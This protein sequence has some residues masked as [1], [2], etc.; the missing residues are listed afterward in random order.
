M[1]AGQVTSTHK[2]TSSTSREGD[3]RSIEETLQLFEP[4]TVPGQHDTAAF[5]LPW[6]SPFP[7]GLKA[8]K[9]LSLSNSIEVIKSF[10][11][12]GDLARLIK[13]HAGAIL[14]RGL[15]IETP[16]DYSKVAHAF[17]FRPHVEVGRPPLRTVLAP[18]VKT[19]NEGEYGWSTI[20]PAW[21]TFS[22]LK[23]PDSGGATPITSAIYIAHELSR[24]K[25]QFLSELLN[26][27][28][29]YVYRYTTNP[30]VSNTGTSIRGAYGQEVTDEDD[31]ITARNKI[32]DEVRR[33]SNRF[34]W[35]EDGSIS[36]THIV[37]VFFGNVTSAW[38]RSRHHGA[39]RP[40]FQGD[41]GSYHPPPTYG[42]GTPIDL[43]DLDLL[44][45]LAED[46]AVDVE[47]EKGDL[48]LLDNYA[49]MH[50]R[51]PWKGTRQVLAA[52]WDDDGRIRDF[53]E[54]VEL[55]KSSPRVPRTEP[56]GT[57]V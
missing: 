50:S 22:A 27:G 46:G 1:A 43:E 39:T 53:P 8:T 38:G 32:E 36:V 20:N 4:F 21:L 40:P 23:L 44:L 14:I 57:S 16:D 28:V 15:P 31:E 42:D 2:D 26:K 12:S 6:S 7:L 35:H 19:A 29:K 56:K 49:V 24:Q 45:K 5:G 41:D 51:K 3:R 55:L 52:L 54:G 48:V 30:L 13:H 17:G 9:A 10:T 25:P 37:P 18:N 11:Q 34:E 33:H 47:W